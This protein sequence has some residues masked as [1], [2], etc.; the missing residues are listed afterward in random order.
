LHYRG[1]DDVSDDWEW[2][3]EIV[4]FRSEL[5]G[6][7]AAALSALAVPGLGAESIPGAL[8]ELTGRQ[9]GPDLSGYLARQA[10]SGQFAEFLAHRSVYQLKEADPHSFGIPRLDG[11]V[12]AALVEI[13]ADEYGSGRPG[14]MHS[15]LFRRA[16]RWLELDDSYG[17]YVPAVPA[18]TLAVSNLMSLFALHRRWLGALLGH[19]AALEMT[20]TQPNRRYAAGARRLGASQQSYWYFTEHVEADAVHEQIAAHDLCGGYAAE[21]PGRVADIL[22]GAACCLALDSQLAAHL[23]NCWEAGDSSLSPAKPPVLAA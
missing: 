5:E 13:Q 15:E 16:M 19:L 21:H 22:F 14:R 1:F 6:R 7:W 18:V 11:A 20:S 3:P 10:T 2:H 23:V 8:A 4:S 12:K 9:D 17:Y